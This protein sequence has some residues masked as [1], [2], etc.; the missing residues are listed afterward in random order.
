MVPLEAGRTKGISRGFS[1]LEAPG[2]RSL[3]LNSTSEEEVQPAGSGRSPNSLCRDEGPLPE[4]CIQNKQTR[5]KSFLLAFQALSCVPNW[6]KLIGCQ[7]AKEKC[8]L[9]SPSPSIQKWSWERWASLSWHLPTSLQTLTRQNFPLYWAS[10]SFH[11]SEYP[12][13]W[14]TGPIF[15]QH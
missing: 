15:R 4:W 9:Q 10:T 2:Q 14:A 6:R 8:S 3:E 11:K 12:A 13:E 5:K 1:D 7:L